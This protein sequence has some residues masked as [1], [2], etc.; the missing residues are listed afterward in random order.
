[1]SDAV[2]QTFGRFHLVVLHFP[3]ALVLTALLIEGFRVIRPRRL[4]RGAEPDARLARSLRLSPSPTACT[5]IVLAA[6]TGAVTAT[7]GWV[8]AG[9]EFTAE[10]GLEWHRWLGVVAA[11]LAA[12]TLLLGV[13]ASLARA[14]VAKRL[15]LCSLVL[16]AIAVGWAGHLGGELVHGEGFILG[17]MF[18]RPEAA[19][20]DPGVPLADPSAATPARP[21]GAP[22][23]STVDQGRVPP[24]FVVRPAS[25]TFETDIEPIFAEYCVKCHRDGKAKGDIR[26]DS[27]ERALRAVIPGNSGESTLVRLIRLPES[28]EDS[29]PKN[30]PSLSAAHV[31]T[32]AT[33]IDGLPESIP[34]PHEPIEIRRVPGPS[35]KIPSVALAYKDADEPID[36]TPEQILARDDAIVRLRGRLI[37]AG[38]RAAGLGG[39]EVRVFENREAFGDDQLDALAGLGPCLVILDLTGTSVTDAALTRLASEF[40]R[41]RVLRLGDTAITDEGVSMLSSLSELALLDVHCTGVTENGLDAV[42]AAPS[43][44]VLRCWR[45]HTGA[46]RLR[47]LESRYPG[48]DFQHG[49]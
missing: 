41:V 40:P 46:D 29:M 38:V 21:G 14:V 30:K 20:S 8:Y 48:V 33:W 35:I 28:D 17:P 19:A 15:Y 9:G 31:V 10:G 34:V 16:C 39:V 2:I 6:I 13:V 5:C 18:H 36:L 22:P 49:E 32:I 24:E 27:R 3:L 23:D 4:P 45:S 1:M 37:S 12:L 25:L 44:R 7:S 42:A 47:E 26:L 11:S 43:L